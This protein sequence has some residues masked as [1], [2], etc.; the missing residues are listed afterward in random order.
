MKN[1]YNSTGEISSPFELFCG[2]KPTISHLTVFGCPVVAK[3]A[4]ISIDGLQT[5]FAQK[6]SVFLLTRKDT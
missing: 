5:T 2:K 4:V 6:K 3:R 1:L